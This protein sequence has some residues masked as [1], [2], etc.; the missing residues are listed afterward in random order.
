MIEIR[1]RQQIV[2]TSYPKRSLILSSDWSI[3]VTDV[4]SSDWSI[5]VTDV[6]SSD[7]SSNVTDVYRR[8]A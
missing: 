7:W 4:L 3:N 8:V 2:K 5:N 1:R 6:L